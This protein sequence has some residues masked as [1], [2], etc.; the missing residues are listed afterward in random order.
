[1]YL[2]S[3]TMF[4]NVQEVTDITIATAMATVIKTIKVGGRKSLNHRNA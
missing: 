3:L 1:M 4:Q 2:L